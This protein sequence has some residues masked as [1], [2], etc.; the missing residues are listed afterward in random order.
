VS[1]R[2]DERVAVVTGGSRGIG[3]GIAR[4]LAGA[5]AVV[6]VTGRAAGHGGG[7]GDSLAD[8]VA[9]I[10]AFGGTA[11]AVPCDHSDDQQ[12]Y[13]LFE[14]IRESHNQ[15]DILV[16]NAFS[17]SGDV[18]ASI[19][20]KFWDLPVNT[21]DRFANVGLR[22]HYAASVMAM[23]MLIAS[24]HGLIV[25]VSSRGAKHYTLNV[26]Y[27]VAK[28]AL[29]RFTADAAIE[30]GGVGVAIVSIWPGVV[31][32]ELVADAAAGVG[33]NAALQ[34]LNAPHLSNLESSDY[35]GRAVLALAADPTVTRRSG[36]AFPVGF[37]AREYGF[38]DIDGRQPEPRW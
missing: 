18:I 38:T 5:G 1:D 35:A 17:A 24:G 27:G 23:P 34:A 25:N 13:D 30:L 8:V 2:L 32:T 3:R 19:G 29:D 33:G 12:V 37:L 10:R 36:G 20:V 31:R 26:A 14:T 22:S 11:I 21:W 9:E 16:N 4:V 28:A 7:S 6:Y 15:I